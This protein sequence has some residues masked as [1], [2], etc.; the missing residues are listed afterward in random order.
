MI[1]KN[2]DF[3]NALST[4]SAVWD[5]NLNLK[6]RF[7]KKQW[8]HKVTASGVRAVN[9]NLHKVFFLEGFCLY[10]LYLRIAI[11]KTFF[12]NFLRI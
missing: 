10:Y 4:K 8:A 11:N 7:L 2:L 6:M 3:E 5:N 9:S 12:L 1:G